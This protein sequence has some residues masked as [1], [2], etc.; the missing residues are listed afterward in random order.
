MKCP[1]LSNPEATAASNQNSIGDRTEK[2][3]LREM[4]KLHFTAVSPNSHFSH[5]SW[6]KFFK[7][8]LT[9]FII[10]DLKTQPIKMRNN[11][12]L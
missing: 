3:I 6:L 1:Q 11:D 7:S 12:N 8:L 4:N 2:K 10:K 5:P 9:Y